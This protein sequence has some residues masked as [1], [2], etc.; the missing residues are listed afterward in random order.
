M[1]PFAGTGPLAWF[2]LRR[3]RLRIALWVVG[4]GALV[5]LSAVSVKGTFPTQ[6]ALDAAVD[7]ERSA[8]AI[9]FNGPPL[10]LNTIGGETAYQLSTF[11]LVV[12]GLMSA[13]MVGRLIRGEE[14]GGRLEL[15]RSLPV[16]A[17]APTAAALLVVAGM[18]L[19][20]GAITTVGLIALDL[21]AMGALVLGAAVTM[22][23]LTFA[24]LAAVTSQVIENTRAVHGVTG[25]VLGVSFIVRGVGDVNG[26]R[27]SWLSPI[28]WA[29]KTRPFAGE[30]WWPLLVPAVAVAV[31]LWCAARLSTHRDLGA[32]LVQPRPGRSRAAPSLG[33]SLGLAMRLHRGT[34]AGWSAGVFA[35]GIA[36][37]S[38]GDS[39]DRYA[40]DNEAMSKMLELRSGASVTDAYFATA[41]TFTALLVASYALQAIFHARTEESANRAEVVVA[42]GRS[43]RQW[44]TA[45]LAATA[46]GTV[47]VTAAGALGTGL[48]YGIVTGRWSKVLRIGTAAFAYLPAIWLV[49]AIAVSLYG[50]LPRASL[51]GWGVLA[52][53]VIAGILG[54]LLDLPGWLRDL[55][56][57]QHTPRVP[58]AAWSFVPLAVLLAVAA[59]LTFAGLVGFDR[60]D[61]VPAM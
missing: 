2:V 60:R 27:W 43:R 58:A 46:I 59:V 33:R 17:Q 56:P 36:Y 5:V 57:I 13:L 14:E 51:L 16:G 6:H 26:G 1:E 24:A 4:I 48:T 19:A 39:I 3:D 29:Q 20:V 47:L 32:A 35:M 34:I 49:V 45:H 40:R 22:L 28:G 44:L 30:T 21:P 8:P 50:V 12:V 31:A 55:S 53:C 25:V 42:T 18:D 41:M 37:G 54:D 9:I 38:I 10:A 7:V 52:W 15:V 11:E 61:L 23:G